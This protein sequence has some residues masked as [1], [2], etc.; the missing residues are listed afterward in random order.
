MTAWHKDVR[1]RGLEADDAGGRLLLLSNARSLHRAL[2]L[3]CDII[4]AATTAILRW[5]F[6]DSPALTWS[7]IGS[8]ILHTSATAGEI[9]LLCTQPAL[10]ARH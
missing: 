1:V 2:F 4:L 8:L 9:F 6:F 3:S 10:L 5:W 7:L